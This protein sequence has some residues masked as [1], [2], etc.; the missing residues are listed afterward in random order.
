MPQLRERDKI[1]DIEVKSADGSA[2]AFRMV[3]SEDAER[4]A[5]YFEGL[6]AATRRRFAPHPLNAEHARLLCSSITD[7][8]DRFLLL[9]KADDT[10]VGYFI[11]DYEIKEGDRVRFLEKGIALQNGLDPMFAPSLADAW[12]GL[13]LASLVMPLIVE[14]AR[15][16]G[17]RSLVL[18]GGTQ[19]TNARALHFYE[20]FGFQ[21]CGGYQTDVFNHDMR[22]IL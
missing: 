19:A 16:R 5:R 3:K 4:L 14:S 9:A 21:R 13:G 1:T 11:L 8:A 2:F 20:K 6:S 15:A 12:Q 7:A 22:L 18:L 17:A 10:V